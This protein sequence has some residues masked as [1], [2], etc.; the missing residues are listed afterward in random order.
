MPP[1]RLVYPILPIWVNGKLMFPLCMKCLM[2]HS[3][4]SCLC[5]DEE[6]CLVHTWT[7]PEV[8]MAINYGY[9]IM[10]TYEILHWRELKQIDGETKKGGIFHSYINMFLNIKA[11]ASGFPADVKM[12]DD[13]KLYINEFKK[14]E[15][16][17]LEQRKLTLNS[18]DG[19]FGQRV[20]MKKCVFF[21]QAEDIYKLLTDYSKKVSNFHV[22]NGNLVVMEYTKKQD[23][24]EVNNRTNVKVATFCTSY[25]RMKLWKLMCSLKGRV[26]Y[27]DT[28]SVIYSC[29]PKVTRPHIGKFLG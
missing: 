25:A 2:L 9:K 20:N 24:M 16:I 14:Q 17:L 18:F 6:R 13:R 19:K 8:E 7:T 4:N 23:F 11:E 15:G 12:D 27:Y 5:S 1:A 21:T 10:H 28:D 3:N 29:T 22:I 26:L